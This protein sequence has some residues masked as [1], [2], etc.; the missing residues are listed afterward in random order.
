MYR[1]IEN[2]TEESHHFHIDVNWTTL[3]RAGEKNRIE[4]EILEEL[5]YI[6]LG[7]HEVR[8]ICLF[9][10]TGSSFFPPSFQPD[11]FRTRGLRCKALPADDV[12]EGLQL[13]KMELKQEIEL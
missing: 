12:S 13:I 7:I 11:C 9:Y 10:V 1:S 2:A 8:P 3:I 4:Y 6:H 5:V